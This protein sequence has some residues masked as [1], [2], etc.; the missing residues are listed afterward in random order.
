M[1]NAPAPSIPRRTDH[2]LMREL[3]AGEDLLDLFGSEIDDD[4]FTC[5]LVTDLYWST[6]YP[7]I[8]QGSAVPLR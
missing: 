3:P 7:L 4:A 1:A 2:L 5:E 6:A 8:P